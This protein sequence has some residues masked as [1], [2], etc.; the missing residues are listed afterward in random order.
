MTY[1][2]HRGNI[3]AIMQ[4]IQHCLDHDFAGS[5]E[6]LSHILKVEF[7]NFNEDYLKGEFD[8]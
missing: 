2:W 1:E 4:C 3:E 6:L 7:D 8:E 5:V